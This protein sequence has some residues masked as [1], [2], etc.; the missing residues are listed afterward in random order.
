M[1][2]PGAGVVFELCAETLEA[3]LAAGPGGADRVELCRK[4]EVGG[5]T[6]EPSLVKAAIRQSGVPVHVLVRPTAEHFL[7]SPEV[8]TAAEAAIA[9]A[10]RAGAAG[11][12]LGLLTA[13]GTVDVERTRALVALAAPLPVTFHRAFDEL[14]GLMARQ[15]GL[16]DVIATGCVRLLTSGGAP[17]VLRG[18]PELAR[19][20]RQAKGRLTIAAGGG[21]RL[22]NAA[23]VAEVSGLHDFHGSLS[24]VAGEANTLSLPERIREIKRRLVLQQPAVAGTGPHA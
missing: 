21:L 15:Q 19:L 2:L 13:T 10:K 24:E 9:E 6:P 5:L 20:R 3:C 12:V 4:L 18:A 23:Q 16:E 14:P 8:I 17:D 7:G 1:S 11:V 22:E